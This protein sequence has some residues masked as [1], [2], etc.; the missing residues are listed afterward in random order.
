M[1]QYEEETKPGFRDC[2][3]NIAVYSNYLVCLVLFVV[4][5]EIMLGTITTIYNTCFVLYF[6]CIK[7]CE[8]VFLSRNRD[9]LL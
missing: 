1:S 3:V 2:T 4:R 9:S 7:Y 6:K 8:D 5:Q